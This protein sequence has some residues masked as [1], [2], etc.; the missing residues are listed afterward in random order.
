[1]SFRSTEF[2]DDSARDNQATNTLEIKETGFAWG[3]LRDMAA[4]YGELTSEGGA[5]A[6]GRPFSVTG[7]SLGGHLATAFNLMYGGV[8]QVQR[9]VTFNGAGVGTFDPSVTPLLQLVNQFAKDVKNGFAQEISSDTLRGVYQRAQ[10][11]LAAKESFDLADQIVLNEMA[12]DAYALIDAKAQEQAVLIKKAMSRADE[13]RAEA[14]RVP[15]LDNGSGQH[16]ATVDSTAIA[17]VNLDYQIAVL[18]ASKSTDAASLF[19]GLVRSYLGKTIRYAITNQFDVQ[20]A[21]TPSAVANSQWH[22]GWNLPIFIEDQPLYRGDVGSAAFLE[23]LGALGIKLLVDGYSSKDFGDTHSLVLLVDSLNVQDTLLRMLPE[24]KRGPQAPTSNTIETSELTRKILTYAS[25]WLKVDGD[26]LYGGSQGKAEGDVLENVVNAL[27]AL[28][29]GAEYAQ[30]NK[31]VGS[32]SGNTWWSLDA[33]GSDD[34]IDRSGRNEF[35]KVLQKIQ[36]SDIFKAANAGTLNLQLN[37]PSGDL[38]KD[39]R[40]DFGA[41]AAL[42][43]LSPFVFKFGNEEQANA[44]FATAWGDTYKQWK[45]DKDALLAVEAG[46]QPSAENQTQF[47]SDEWLKDR[48]KLLTRKVYFN[49]TNASY[50]SSKPPTNGSKTNPETTPYDAEDIVWD[51]HES[52]LKIQRGQKTAST[53]YVVFGDDTNESLTGD[54]RNDHLYG[55]KGDDVVAGDKGDD[56][57][58][59]NAGKDN[60]DGG[61]GND[62]LLGGDD[63]DYLDGGDGFDLLLGGRG[64]DILTGGKGNDALYG[65]E[66][67]DDLK[68]NEGLDFLNGGIGRDT[69]AG[70]DSNDYL[71]DEGGTDYSR[72]SGDEGNDILE[73]KG[74]Q[75]AVDLM[76]G[77]GNDL[78]KGGE[79]PNSLEGENGNDVIIG[80][81]KRDT[82]KGGN[83]AD[84]IEA[85]GGDDEITGGAGAD[86]MRGGAGGDSYV[87]EGSDFGADLISDDSGSISL[88]SSSLS[89]GTFEAKTLSFE[90]NGYEYRKF[91][92]GSFSALMINA[93]GDDQNTIF[94]DRWQ[95]G[96]LGINL[97]GQEDDPE[98]PDIAPVTKNARP[99]NNK[100]DVIHDDGGDGGQGNDILIGTGDKSLLQGG[101]G[102]DILDGRDGDDWL[103][104][105]DGTDLILTGKGKDV[106]Y[107]GGDDDIVRVG[108]TLD[109]YDG[110]LDTGEDGL[111]YG[112]G[113]G[114][115][116]VAGTNTEAEFIFY[117]NGEERSIAHPQLAVFD[118][119]FSPKIDHGD[120]YDG[121]LWWWNVG[122]PSVNS[123]PSLD[124]T[125]TLGDPENVRRNINLKEAPSS[126][127]GKGIDYKLYLGNAK[128]I[129]QAST[130]EKGARVWG[131]DGNDIL[132]GGNESDKM[133]GD[134]DD[135][136]LVGYDGSD[137]L[138]G[139][140]GKDELSGGN[141]RDFLDGGTENDT[142]VGGLGADV[143]SGG[144]GDDELNGDAHYLKGTNWYPSG[145]DESKMGGDLLYGGAGND[146]L[147][148]NN[149]DDYQFGGAQ[150]DTLSGGADNDHLFGEE[151]DDVLMGGG[152]D[153]Y[154][155]GGSGADT[156]Y[157]DA[158]GKDERGRENKSKDIFFGRAGDDDLDGGAGDDIL[159]GGDDNDILTGGDGNDIL[160]GGAGKDH[161]YGDNGAK[162]PGMDILEGGSGDDALAG[163][164]E[165]DMYVF[166]L[167]DGKDAIQDDG[168]S[169]D[170]NIIV[171]KFSQSSIKK[172]ER[173][174]QDL[175]ISYG[176]D[177]SVTV[178]GYY[179]G[180][181]SQGYETGSVPAAEDEVREPQAA[182]AQICFEDG[183]AWD[184]EDIYELA[185]PPDEPFVDPF[186]GA[187]LPY[188][189]NAL[190]SRETIACAGKHALTYCFAETFSGGEN[191]AY[192]FSE[193][194]KAAVRAALAKFSAVIDVSF[195]EVSSDEPSNLRYILDDLSSADLGAFAGYATPFTGEIHL[196]SG[197]FSRQYQNEFGEYVTKQSL[198]EGETGFEVLLH[199]TGH[200]LGLKHPFESPLLPNSENNNEN[201]VM[202]YT[203]TVEPARDLAAF[204]VAALQF[205]YGVAQNTKTGDDTYT[206]TD[207][208]VYDAAGTD[209]FDATLET[210]GVYIDLQQGG[211]SSVGEPNTSI[212]AP[213]Q[214][215]VGYGTDV[216]N[217]IGGSGNDALNGN[218]LANKM[219]GGEGDDSIAGNGGDDLLQGG[220]GSDTYYFG[221]TDGE[222]TIADAD[223]LSRIEL[224]DVTV[225]QVYWRDGYLYHGTEGAR[226]AIELNQIAELVIGDISYAGQ[227]IV[228]AFGPQTSD[229]ADL[230]LPA[231]AVDGQLTGNGDWRITGNDR[232]NQLQGN[233]GNN[234]L[235]GGAGADTLTGGLGDDTYLVSNPD[236]REIEAP[237]GGTD[238]VESSI[239]YALGDNVENLTLTGD[240]VQGTGNALANTLLGNALDNVLA[241][242]AGGDTYLYD[243]GQGNDQIIEIDA[244]REQTDVLRL[245][246]GIDPTEVQATRDFRDVTLT[247]VDGSQLV[248]KSQLDAAGTGIERV[249]F[250]NGTV[251][252]A[253]EL[254]ELA[255]FIYQPPQDFEGSDDGEELIGTDGSDRITGHRGNDTLVGGYGEDSLYG[256][257]SWGDSWGDD[258]PDDDVLIGG[259]NDDYLYGGRRADHDTL[260]GGSGDDTYRFSEGSGDDVVIESG[261]VDNADTVIFEVWNGANEILFKR[262]GD[263]LVARLKRTEDRL[264]IKSFFSAPEAVVETFRFDG[265][266]GGYYELSAADVRAQLLLGGEGDDIILGYESADQLS[267]AGGRDTLQG[268]VGQDTLAG[269]LDSD[270]LQGGEDGDTY[271]YARGD[272]H[273][274]IIDGGSAGQDIIALAEGIDPADITVVRTDADLILLIG[275]TQDRIL[276]KQ[277]FT[278]QGPSIEAV[279]FANGTSW[280]VAELS[281]MAQAMSSQGSAANDSLQGTLGND[282]LSALAGDDT[283]RGGLGHDLL[284]GGAGDDGYVYELGD[285]NDLIADLGE[286]DIDT[287]LMGDGIDS[288]NVTV[289]R[290][291]ANLYLDLPDGAVLTIE[292]WFT[293]AANRVATVR[294]ANGDTWTES[295]LRAFAKL[296][297]SGNDYLLGE[298]GDDQL[299]GGLGNDTLLG[300]GGQDTLEGGLGNDVLDG[301]QG[302]DRYVFNIGDGNDLITDA[303]GNAVLSFGPGINPEDIEVLYDGDGDGDG[304]GTY[305]LRHYGSTD[306][307]RIPVD[308]GSNSWQRQPMIARVEFD[309]GTVW[310]KSDVGD[311]AMSVPTTGTDYLRGSSRAELIDG[312]GGGDV[313]FGG[314]GAD[315]YVY[316]LGYGPLTINDQGWASLDDALLLGEGIAP[317]DFIVSREYY[318]LVLSIEGSDDRITI[319]DY[320]NTT[321]RI[322]RIV[323]ANGQ[324]WTHDDV[325]QRVIVPEGTAAAEYIFGSSRN[326][327]INGK[328]GNDTLRGDDGD[329]TYL[330]NAN[331]GMD[332]I[333][334]TAGA[335]KIVLDDGLSVENTMVTTVKEYWWNSTG[336]D[337]QT[338]IDFG[339]GVTYLEPG[340][341]M[342]RIESANGTVL[343]S[344][345]DDYRQHDI[346]G[347]DGNDTLVGSIGP[348]SMLG[349]YGADV[350]KGG[351][352]RD[353]LDGGDGNDVLQGG[354]GDDL[355]YGSGGHDILEGGDGQDTL[356]GNGYLSG[357]ADND[358]IG[359]Y[360]GSIVD[361]GA[362]DDTLRID[363]DGVVLFGKGSGHD[364]ISYHSLYGD[365]RGYVLKVDVNTDEVEVLGGEIG[366]VKQPISLRITSTGDAM[367]GLEHFTDIVFNDGTRWSRA[368]VA[369]KAVPDMTATPQDDTLIGSGL[370]DVIDGG[371][372]NDLIAGG[373][374]NDLIRSGTGRDTLYGNGG[375]DTLIGND[376]D[377]TINGGDGDDSLI[378]GAG[379]DYLTAGAGSN[380]IDGGAGDD[381]INGSGATGTNTL[382]FNRDSGSDTYY[383]SSDTVPSTPALIVI[384]LGANL[385]P[386][387]IT[388]ERTAPD[389]W[390]YAGSLVMQV[391]DA[392]QK[393]VFSNWFGQETP[394]TQLEVKFANGTVW[395][396][397]EIFTTFGDALFP[398]GSLQG[399]YRDNLLQGTDSAERI[400][401]STGNDTLLGLGDNDTLQGGTGNDSLMGGDGNDILQGGAGQDT[402]D[403]GA[404]NDTYDANESYYTIGEA[405]TFVFG[406]GSGTDTVTYSTSK[407]VILLGEGIRLEDL[408]VSAPND[409]SDLHI[410][411]TASPD[412][413]LRIQNWRYSSDR[414]NTIK[415]ANGT[416]LDLSQTPSGP[417][418]TGSGNDSIYEPKASPFNDVIY[419]MEGS[420]ALYGGY[421][422]DTINGGTG[423]DYLDGGSGRNR[424]DGGAGND[425]YFTRS[426]DTVVFGF[427]SGYD[428]FAYSYYLT[429]PSV[430]AFQANVQL[431]DVLIQNVSFTERGFTYT[432][433]LK[434]SP[435][436]VGLLTGEFDVD[437]QP[438]TSTRFTFGDGQ[439]VDGKNIFATLYRSTETNGSDVLFGTSAA[440]YLD[441]GTGDDR[442]YG[443]GGD[444]MLLGGAGVDTLS[445]GSGSDTLVGGAGNDSLIGGTG[446]DLYRFEAT[447]GRDTVELDRYDTNAEDSISFDAGIR[448][449]DVAVKYDGSAL[450]LDVG[451]QQV[452]V[453]NGWNGS[454]VGSGQGQS[455][456]LDEIRFADGTVW[457]A[458]DIAARLIT[459][460][461]GNDSLVGSTGDDQMIG[462]DGQDLLD[463]ALGSDTLLGGRGDDQLLGGQGLDLLQGGAGNDL[464]DGGEGSD[465]YVFNLGDGQDTIADFGVGDRDIDTLV[466]GAGIHASDV[467]REVIDGKLILHI[468]GSADIIDTITLLGEGQGTLGVERIRFADGTVLDPVTW[469]QRHSEVSLVQGSGDLEASAGSAFDTLLIGAGIAPDNLSVQRDGDDLLVRAGTDSLRFAGWYQTAKTVPPLMQVRFDEGTLWTASELLRLASTR[470]GT[471]LSDTLISNGSD[472]VSLD[473]KA[474]ND[475]LAGGAGDD[476]LV[477][478]EGN[479]TLIGS[480][481]ADLLEGGAGDDLY[482]VDELDQVVELP[483]GGNDMVRLLSSKDVVVSGEIESVEIMGSVAV[484]ITGNAGNNWLIGNTAVNRIEGGEGSDTLDGGS[485]ADYLAGGKG[486]DR[487][488]VDNA[489]DTVFE[490]TGEGNDTIASYISKTLAAD[491]AIE[492][493]ELLGEGS[494][495]ATGNDQV[496][497]L[498]GN[499]AANVLKGMGGDDRLDGGAG[500]DRMSGGTGN[501]TYIVD[502][503]ADQ[504]IELNGEGNDEVQASASFALGDYVE[505]L[506]LTGSSNISGSGNKQDNSVFGNSGNNDL[507]GLEGGD[508]LTG[509]AG[510]DMMSGGVGSDKYLFYVGDGQDTINDNDSTS[511]SAQASDVLELQ[512]SIAPADLIVRRVGN[513]LI[514][515]VRDTQDRLTIRNHFVNSGAI[516]VIRF[517]NGTEW[518]GTDIEAAIIASKTNAAPAVS[519]AQSD[520][521]INSGV[522]FSLDLRPLFIDADAGDSLI[523]KVTLGNGD[524][525][526]GWLH[527]DARNS[528]LYG[529]PGEGDVGT[530]VIKVQV[531]DSGNQGA[532]DDFNL[533]IR[534]PNDTSPVLWTPLADQNGRQG[535]AFV[536]ALPNDTFKD[537]DV[538]DSLSY[539]ATLANG[540]PLPDWLSFNGRSGSFSGT[541]GRN[542][543]GT[544]SVTVTA[545]DT[546]GRTTSDTFNIVIDDI[547]DPP[548]VQRVVADQVLWQGQQV[549][550]TLPADLF[551]DREGLATIKSVS[552][553]SGEALPAWLHYDAATLRLSGTADATSVGATSVRVIGSDEQGLTAFEDFNVIVGD[554]ND[555][556][557]L[558][559]IVDTLTAKEGGAEAI[560]LPTGLF[561]DADRGDSLSYSLQLLSAPAHAKNSFSLT[562]INGALSLTPQRNYSTFLYSALDYWDVGTWSFKLTA[563]DRLGLSASTQFSVDVQASGENHEPIWVEA[564]DK[565]WQ[566]NGSPSFNGNY[567]RYR[568][569]WGFRSSH[570]VA[571]MSTD[572]VPVPV[573][574]F[575]DVDND[576]LNFTVLLKDSYTLGD[577]VY[578]PDAHTL[579]YAGTDPAPRRQDFD[580]L[581]D[582]GKGGRSMAQMTVV[583]NRKPTIAPIS[584]IVV[585]EDE[586]FQVTLPDSLFQDADGDAIYVQEVGS[587][588]RNYNYLSGYQ[589]YW[590][591]VGTGPDNT[592]VIYGMPGDFAP[593]TY[594]LTLQATD[595]YAQGSMEPDG[596]NQWTLASRTQVKVT[597]LNSYD[598]PILRTALADQAIKEGDNFALGTAVNFLEKD[599]DQ[600]LKYSAKLSNGQALPTW[601]KIN[602]STGQL[603]GTANPEDVGEYTIQV[604]ATDLAGGTA[605]DEFTLS[606]SLSNRNHAPRLNTPVADQVYRKDQDFSFQVPRST[607]TDIDANDALSYKATLVGG[608]ALPSWIT[609]N[610]STLTFSGHV[611]ATQRAATEIQ[612]VAT[613]KSGASVADVFSLGID[614][615]TLP[616][617]VAQAILDTTAQEDNAFSFVV[618][619]GTFTDADPSGALTLSASLSNGAA[620]PAW[621]TFDP[622]SRSFSGTPSNGDVG[623][624]QVRVTATE[625][626]SG[627]VS[628]TFQITV[629]NV[630]DAPTVQG[631]SLTADRSGL[632]QVNGSALLANDT[633]ADATQDVLSI[634][635]VGD[636]EYG[637]VSISPQGVVSFQADTGFVGQARFSY[638]VSDGKG[639]STKAY[640]TVDVPRS[641]VAPEA[642]NGHADLNEDSQRALLASDFGFSDADG[643][644]EL[645]S[646]YVNPLNGAGTLSLD[647]QELSVATWINRADLDAGKL[648]FTPQANAFADGYASLV[649]K[650]NDGLES[651]N[652]ATLVLN[653][654]PVNDAPVIVANI[655][656]VQEDGITTTSGNLL[657]NDSDADS[658]DAL[659]IKAP[660]TYQ[661]TYGTLVIQANGSY[662]YTLN[663]ADA[664]V[665][666]LKQ[667]QQVTDS[668]SL[669]VTDGTATVSNALQVSITGSNDAP[670]TQIDQASLQEDIKQSVTGNALTND[671]DPDFGDQLSLT[672][673]GTYQGTYGTLV[674]QASGTYTYT[675]KNSN[676]AVQSL[677]ADQQVTESFAYTAQDGSGLTSL[678]S[679]KFTV[680]GNND[681]PIVFK[682][683]ADQSVQAKAAFTIDLPDDSFTDVDQGTTL[684]YTA[685][686]DDGCALPSWLTFNPSGLILSGTPVQCSGGQTLAIKLKATD[687]YGASSS[688]SFNLSIASSQ[689]VTLIGT[690]F[691][692]NLVGTSRDDYIDGSLGSDKMTGGN[693]DDTYVVCEG[694]QL[695]SPGDK[696]I[697]NADEGYDTVKSSISYTLTANV[698]ALQLTGLLTFNGTGN[699]L[700]NWL[701]GNDMFNTLNGLDGND[702]ISAGCGDDALNG[703]NGADVLEGQYGCDVL[704]GGAGND[705]LFGGNDLDGLYA[706]SGAAF[707]AGGADCDNLYT[708]S[709][710]TVIAYNRGDGADNIYLQNA[711]PLTLSFGGGIK[712]ADVSLRR[713]SND[714]YFD[715]SCTLCDSIRVVNYYQMA[716]KP[717][718]TLQFMLES[719]GEYVA[720]GADKLRDNKVERYDG[721][722]IIADFNAAMT[723]ANCLAWGAQWNG[724]MSSLL[725]AQFAGSG[726]DTVAMGGDLAYLYA[727]KNVAGMPQA[728]ANGILLDPQFALTPQ[729][730]NQPML[731][732]CGNTPALAG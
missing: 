699:D 444:D 636:A 296:A 472:P 271:V 72:L 114:F 130:G 70:G 650:V 440:N 268:Q 2:I 32:Q 566:T 435:A 450:V 286:G 195:T 452:R 260:Q 23:S 85:G 515:S 243:L 660:G 554:V 571:T 454:Y 673:V 226:I 419:G 236:D 519:Q 349:G 610:A 427:D 579:H 60:L 5:L 635:A 377:V 326:D 510:A 346:N 280:S 511:G 328:G 524:A 598:A 504:A 172:V 533:S 496:N 150:N 634:S 498:V 365:D 269:G 116:P 475:Y 90:G 649:F 15:T 670:S 503:S 704:K 376:K 209:T 370:A 666:G 99:E 637:A 430:I 222:D 119:K 490:I 397:N 37:T 387:D 489:A 24:A 602:A 166:N 486:N 221:V 488:V 421:G 607:F 567:N 415:L 591:S 523:P 568:D 701:I 266:E 211:W 210:E 389:Y 63:V 304:A 335:N 558:N 345:L 46:N 581:V 721:N 553:S 536:F 131:G 160:R 587:A 117:V 250:A 714:L 613:D 400:A 441:A 546:R 205:L 156:L 302:E 247:F 17:Q 108:Y 371:S 282:V 560:A 230:I 225:D 218:Q 106:V 657:S 682:P 47:V 179:N 705:A 79:G 41:Y 336:H 492:N 624:W 239:D 83:D 575:I 8:A 202:S 287:V 43:S 451:G 710:A 372:G 224:F 88:N 132:Y 94:V 672:T 325:M 185:P 539:S 548:R 324:Q 603:Y 289:R 139:D 256:D 115:N 715:F 313:I 381:Y 42:Y 200:A 693:G 118:L 695:L 497:T 540:Q 16:P 273:D 299:S 401:G 303:D 383:T 507:Y 398:A 196:N 509:G 453:N 235:D 178:T 469:R 169:G 362:G 52:E 331:S 429:N 597:V 477:G 305:I 564:T 149:G 513:D 184:R 366:D 147:W 93:K 549:D 676:S 50:D 295:D 137:E 171:F 547:N 627:S 679:V 68:G 288:S 58:E 254:K 358:S 368:D 223:G 167:G 550:I 237:D 283:L 617:V 204:D 386:D 651:S 640:V 25:N 608:G 91:E 719:S 614:E 228:D 340:T 207:K 593:G 501:D 426:G 300:G 476:R 361:G 343:I 678:S 123:E 314:E 154:L 18:K 432:L 38:A 542:N 264:T 262:D 537:F 643:P 238:T 439:V 414:I 153:D 125:V 347:T 692:D 308:L 480:M 409:S 257:D 28:T 374:G 338:K 502:D 656:S 622:V 35:Y 535:D 668:F 601:L 234:V 707:M 175:L 162:T 479:D 294:F 698:E 248:L 323:F 681:A 445:G 706:E 292:D 467:S 584:E 412:D 694:P 65:G 583:A 315:R 213:K 595:A 173:K 104:G 556:P 161:L 165:S 272:G 590:G 201:T 674:L 110:K 136:V 34:A 40:K 506:F 350:M 75:G 422:D 279:A 356:Y 69:L 198:N 408:Q 317:Q 96:Q 391:K 348:D 529:T 92:I 438:T 642:Q 95:D 258:A 570:V 417:I 192:L 186:A 407:D 555:A 500:A 611:P 557:V 127:L 720:G 732:G 57:L 146:K 253:A 499:I 428:S 390:E 460:T 599:A 77:E 249:E 563:T 183:T 138:Y 493:I 215:F 413:V 724:L 683:I 382:R 675:L 337:G 717:A 373:D 227:A 14:L 275:T 416:T 141:G 483:G 690:W 443:A 530:L 378:G 159:D 188:F 433:G 78:L 206:F 67:D 731:V 600:T 463:G 301:G 589:E 267:G 155:D 418:I 242:G 588:L 89:G 424:L 344:N 101:V 612:I 251:W 320:F 708:G 410:S 727:N 632:L 442:A 121:K 646:V 652:T 729:T 107:A 406:H 144:T 81:D 290:D 677:G 182:I 244:E 586:A 98:R 168:G 388:F 339:W 306:Q 54:A 327:V 425:T 615:K 284:I 135:D 12:L 143:L 689:G 638:T 334:D 654:K 73:I 157:D 176:T 322:E 594:Y 312:L 658:G 684:T 520:L 309:N 140:A 517:S 152:G 648:V 582:D 447:F 245:G 51:D 653:V 33:V 277:W 259:A 471:E 687:Q 214:S 436:R 485:G 111:F 616:P 191:N 470:S 516:E 102:N 241:G 22:I 124:I 609:F 455:L 293:E 74:G 27:A 459:A 163:G 696:V 252:S 53:R 59:G 592:H 434:G 353:T 606:V 620:L 482:V 711:S 473:G 199:E 393:L 229:S 30:K 544:T 71:Y 310:S 189:V 193:E 559:R 55:G 730:I 212:L 663:N 541:P 723:G 641:N 246:A 722:K 580:I 405:D 120:N 688:D 39:A 619:S 633:D 126:N 10:Q 508:T 468:A 448:P 276:V 311:Y 19:G 726:S 240:A 466:F 528:R 522:D 158:D 561:T 26:L 647:G 464:L 664:A 148:G 465:T 669:D 487:Y 527:L 134:A 691:N 423:S 36:D 49:E 680:S 1:M 462:Q 44:V 122:D 56:Y 481:G 697:E 392:S 685:T 329:D 505:R 330:I 297:T 623:V 514:L 216:E 655:A 686:L 341:R 379:N 265:G 380:I 411:L 80:G 145:L 180:G 605:Q 538:Y 181:F 232:D 461:S 478:G 385:T 395:S 578:D 307:V 709:T 363:G 177:D 665:Q 97:S 62:T 354:T 190:L 255:A 4:W 352:G 639:G 128:D 525:L 333:G 357:G 659:A 82:I 133:H 261:D 552:L 217:A 671:S 20:G 364:T 449:A 31:L 585:R 667:D 208:Y 458:A 526:P 718:I 7:Y 319:D 394:A 112:A 316:K 645:Q 355:L 551:V 66:S 604:I 625:P 569:S 270:L 532:V 662:T 703:G 278:S 332:V 142:L 574:Q 103:E 576:N 9:T 702:L 399:D 543:V 369:A 291:A 11:A 360:D 534:N 630:N 484:N 359:A 545:K 572:P 298:D 45:S 203:R 351:A 86:Y 342:D 109:W 420:D 404:G 396:N 187:N 367:T 29:L 100:V 129:L 716:T 164:G 231:E 197:L 565:P 474:G 87:Y 531:S 174:G 233:D 712:Y 151:D 512:D 64:D 495:N 105:G 321:G 491:D 631:E 446:R 76:G 629:G 3:Q 628:D 618:P 219:V 728:N 318:S 194:Q 644:A 573:D 577:W 274:T 285:G 263:D 113:S 61:K 48:A 170:Q 700:D 281:D 384:E 725:Q 621:L 402:Y 456:R 21:T 375:D 562:N 713:V 661:G 13:I 457:K 626:D 437:G 494:I 596:S 518:R 431:E 6:G 521:L 84:Y 220:A 403:G